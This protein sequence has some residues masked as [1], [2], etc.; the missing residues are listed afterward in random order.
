MTTY[1]ILLT[2]N[3]PGHNVLTHKACILYN[4]I[5]IMALAV[6][7]TQLCAYKIKLERYSGRD[8]SQQVS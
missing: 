6:V 4:T 3:I 1:S 2:Y 5:L 8:H 7:C